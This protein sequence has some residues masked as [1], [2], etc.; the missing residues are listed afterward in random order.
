MEYFLISVVVVGIVCFVGNIILTWMKWFSVHD[1]KLLNSFCNNL[2]IAVSCYAA[3]ADTTEFFV[4]DGLKEKGCTEEQIASA[5]A[6]LAAIPPL[7]CECDGKTIYLVEG[8]GTEFETRRPFLNDISIWG[9][10]SKLAGRALVLAKKQLRR[11]LQVWLAIIPAIY[12]ALIWNAAI[13]WNNAGGHTPPDGKLD[14]VGFSLWLLLFI[15][16]HQFY[17]FRLRMKLDFGDSGSEHVGGAHSG[18]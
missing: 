11:R 15:G 3:R 16:G 12:T 5:K 18:K 9:K 7:M 4:V 6:M 2:E 10:G 13:G 14:R 1:I 8:S 17:P